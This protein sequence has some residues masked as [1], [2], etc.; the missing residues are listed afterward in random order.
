MRYYN[1]QIKEH[2]NRLIRMETSD[3]GAALALGSIA[4]VLIL[5]PLC[6]LPVIIVTD[7]VF[8]AINNPLNIF[9]RGDKL[10]Q[11]IVKIFFLV[12]TSI[13]LFIWAMRNSM[14]WV[15]ELALNK[16]IDEPRPIIWFPVLIEANVC[17]ALYCGLILLMGLFGWHFTATGP[18][19]EIAARWMFE[20]WLFPLTEYLNGFL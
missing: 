2:V 17:Y 10:L 12:A 8:E 9:A 16:H 7:V 14:I 13:P 11:L 1:R 19:A 6:A 20:D 5:L 3:G 4:F 15:T 18:R